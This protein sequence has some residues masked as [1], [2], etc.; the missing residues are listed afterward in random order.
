VSLNEAEYAALRHTINVRG[1]V[2]VALMV[3]AVAAWAAI[4][5][6]LLLYSDL[7]IAA[8]VPLAV[9]ASGFEAVHALH[10][11]VERIG[12]YIQV[13]HEGDADGPRWETTAMVA[14]P[15]LPGG[16]V[17]PLFALTFG[18]CTVLN[19]IPAVLPEPDRLEFAVI[20]AFHVAFIVRV[21]TA[22]LAATRQRAVELDRFT[23][24]RMRKD[25]PGT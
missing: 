23:A 18:C 4:V 13:F 14:G 15:A 17:D 21:L 3:F 16:G 10:V 6:F 2:R 8:L 7:P 25:T 24:L 11:G 5:A 22:R 12:R 9:L 20:A 19:L 1:T